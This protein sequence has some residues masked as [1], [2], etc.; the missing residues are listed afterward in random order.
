MDRLTAQQRSSNM[1]RIGARDTVPELA[2][3]KLLHGLGYRYRLYVASLPG[4]P[5]LVFPG[6]RKVVFV[7]GCFWHQ[8]SGCPRSFLPASRER[9]WSSKFRENIRRD[10]RIVAELAE[11]G[12]QALIIWECE[13]RNP[14]CLAEKI[15]AF[16]GPSRSSG[17]PSRC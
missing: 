12:W 8:H 7:H 14:S 5:D 6:R 10:L 11:Q 4:K 9:F 16:L 1:A 15:V 13:T 3:R 2:V 17:V